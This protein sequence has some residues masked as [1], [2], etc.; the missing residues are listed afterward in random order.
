MAP[1]FR[2]PRWF[3]RAEEFLDQG[4]E[5]IEDEDEVEVVPPPLSRRAATIAVGHPVL[6]ASV[7]GVV[8][9]ALAVRH[10]VGS[11]AVTGG[12]LAAFPGSAEDFFRE[13]FSGVRTTVL[14]GAQPASPA[15][16]ALGVASWLSFGS[17]ALAG[18][19][20]LGALP[21]LM[22]VLTYR[23]LVRQTGRPG[24]AVVASA[25]FA[26]S[27]VGL[28]AFSEG[29]IP[30][31]V[32]MAALPVIWDRFDGV[33][34]RRR[35]E[36][37][38]RSGVA[39]GVVVAIAISFDPGL[40]L[41]VALIAAVHLVAG[42]RRDR[43]VAL[44]AL[45]AA[46]AA[47]LAFPVVA[48]VLSAPTE[49]LSSSVGTSDPWSVL[50]L[51]P[52]SAPGS[53]GVAAFLPI[54]ALVCFAS[55]D[56]DRRGRAWRAMM[57]AVAATGLAWA[58]AAGYLP[59]AVSNAPV[60]LAT[61]ALAEAATI[62]Y[63]APG[64]VSGLH[65]QA[66]GVRQIAAAALTVVLG[67]GIASQALQVVLAEWEVRP[68]GLPPAWP[69]V[70]SAAP[71]EFRIVW[72]GAA[73]GE[74]FPAPGGDPLGV[75]AAGDASVRYGM[76]DRHGESA[77]D[78]GRASYGP[79]Y[80]ALRS[81]LDE[82][83]AGATS[84]AGAMLG[85]LGVRYLVAGAGDVPPAALARLDAQVDLDRVPAGGLVIY[86]NAANLPTAYVAT[87]D[88]WVPSADTTSPS[89]LAARPVVRVE[90]LRPP[91]AAVAGRAAAPGE[92]VAAD[93][94]DPG[95]RIV[96]DGERLAPRRAFGWGIAASVGAGEVSF[97][98]ADQWMRTVEMVV[99]AIVW[100]AAL[101]ITRKPGSA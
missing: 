35:P 68:N 84:H 4:F 22:A 16:A 93:Q 57:V 39:L 59:K 89:E 92:A 43:G 19:V 74:R 21:P 52:G 20:V 49:A 27:G 31:L 87:D 62:A 80:V 82:L 32:G 28:W 46:S 10:L 94:F 36:R 63:G 50:R 25:A 101:W 33:F 34:G 6:V 12:A 65:R 29:R 83:F 17:T 14:G 61:A 41:G 8:L 70:D 2:V 51:A 15:L 81:A 47:A 7:V 98:Y 18:K 75:V 97:V 71:G 100:L 55:V 78:V 72:F 5:G 44:A 30:L 42:R 77:L 86:A 54:A 9:G 60:Y 3:E 64:L 73:G 66:F 24:S 48:E 90:R 38:V 53:W 67:V 37:P 96:N 88:R 1:T 13:L 11:E 58:S 26:L 56:R 45:G 91:G 95:W 99:L 23:A 69:V 85:P 79:G 76:T 40:L